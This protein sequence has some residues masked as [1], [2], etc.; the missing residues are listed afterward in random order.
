MKENY[1]TFSHFSIIGV[2]ILALSLISMGLLLPQVIAEHGVD[3]GITKPLDVGPNV[4]D[5]RDTTNIML[6]SSTL[7]IDVRSIKAGFITIIVE[8]KDANLDSSG[9]DVVLSSATSTSSGSVEATVELSET[10]EDSGV[11]TGKLFVSLSDTSGDT[12]ELRVGD[13]LSIFYD[14]EPLSVGRFSAE[15]DV[16]SGAGTVEMKDVI[17]KKKSDVACPAVLFTHPVEVSLSPGVSASSISTTLQFANSSPGNN[18]FFTTEMLY[19]PLGSPFWQTLT[20]SNAI[21]PFFQDNSKHDFDAM[22]IS[23]V[24]Q[25]PNIEGQ[26]ALGFLSGGCSGGGGGGLVRPGLVVNVI[27]GAGSLIGLFTGGSDRA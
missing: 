15:I 20:P 11:F 16:T 12:V 18:K 21:P 10:S 3:P 13:D 8:E 1:F 17:I 23:N 27:G 5:F 6:Q 7:S 19:K 4:V 24:L 22:T 25:P 14:P 2:S 26:Y 9:I